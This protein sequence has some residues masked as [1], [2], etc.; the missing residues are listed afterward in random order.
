MYINF[1]MLEKSNLDF[2]DLLILQASKQNKLEDLSE[3]LKQHS[4]PR[5]DNLISKQFLTKIK[6][7]KSWSEERKIRI[8]SKAKTILDNIE[9]PEIEEQDIRVFDWISDVYIRKGKNIGNKKNAKM[10]IALFRANSGI[11]KNHL[12]TLL[13]KFA[14]DDDNMQYNFRLDYTFFKPHSAYQVKFE[15]EQSRLY[16]YYLNNKSEFDSLFSK[17]ELHN[18]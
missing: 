16:Q 7:E 4:G 2:S 1:K 13:E 12:A 10:Y 5:I 6:G 11:E 9:T 3:V 14:S 15:I 17:I 18:T 8:T